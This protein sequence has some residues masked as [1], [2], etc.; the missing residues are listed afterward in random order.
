MANVERIMSEPE[1]RNVI[2]VPVAS[3]TVVEKGDFIL[4][5]Q[6][7]AITP[8]M[9]GTIYSSE[10]VARREGRQM[11][12]G[13]ATSASAAGETAPVIVDIGLEG[14]WKLTQDAAAAASVADLY[15]IA[16]TG[17]GVAWG[18]LDQQVEP[19][20]SY[21]IAV[22]VDEKQATGTDIY[23]KALP[24]KLFNVAHSYNICDGDSALSYA[25]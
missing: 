24:G 15:G 2:K 14:L 19:D 16:A 12:A 17:S 25:G 4:I 18:L 6:G 1:P 9:L 3:A 21:P 8:S 7:N 13:I 23:C 20:C 11:F 10:T 22:L 5:Y